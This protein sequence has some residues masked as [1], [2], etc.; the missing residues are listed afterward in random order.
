MSLNK[1]C[2]N[3]TNKACSRA[4]S[5]YIKQKL[6]E[7]E[8][9]PRKFWGHLKPLVKDAT[10]GDSQIELDGSSM[11]NSTATIFNN[12]FGGVGLDLKNKITPLDCTESD[13]LKDVKAVTPDIVRPN[14]T[15]RPTNDVEVLAIV[16]KLQNHKASGIPNVSTY[17]LKECFKATIHQVVH[18]INLSISTGRVP[19]DWKHA[20]ITPVHKSGSARTPDNFRPISILPITAKI[21]EK[22][23]HR[24]LVDYLENYSLLTT[25]QFGFRAGH[26]TTQAVATLMADIYEEYNEN[27][28]TRL[29]FIDLKKAF[30]TVSYPVL[31]QKMA[32]VGI[33]GNEMKWFEDYLDN[34]LQAVK[35]NGVQS[36]W[37]RVWCG[38]P[39]A[40]SLGPLLFLLYIYDIGQYIDCRYLLFADDT[41]LYSSDQDFGKATT[42]LQRNLDVLSLWTRGS[43]LTINA[44]KSKT[45]SV[46]PYNNQKK[47]ECLL[48]NRVLHLGND[49][50]EE[51]ATYKYLGVHIDK[52]L[53]FTTQAKSVLKNAA[54]KVYL[55]AKIRSNLTVKAA[56]DVFKV[57]IL[58]LL[59]QGDVFYHGAVKVHLNRLQLIQNRAIRIIHKIPRLCNVQEIC[60]VICNESECHVPLLEKRRKL[61]LAQ[62]AKWLAS[63][64]AYRDKIEAH[65]RSHAIDRIKL[66]VIFPRKQK[67]KHS[68]LYQ[69]AILWND[70]PTYLHMVT[71]SEEF[72][73][74]ILPFL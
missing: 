48:A 29:Y 69:A 33:Q 57:M 67:V 71:K 46:I 39:Q 15:L 55:L 24:Q 5:D 19:D 27:R 61:H 56:L 53:S 73:G 40:S 54:H 58:P 3:L 72:K 7:D 30:D 37:V 64:Q 2:R 38:V 74:E 25:R 21:L 51:V 36:G 16:K 66:R 43:A 28:C 22:C 47:K 1:Q 14:F 50:L 44:K 42:E 41:V 18:L 9:N 6:K 13:N 52:D 63:Q 68:F 62:I 4:K 70:L 17:L 10:K 60:N 20:V 34:R 31:F 8:G 12:F 35:A 59:D 11:E 23:V 65:T 49:P 45:M 26:S 32:S